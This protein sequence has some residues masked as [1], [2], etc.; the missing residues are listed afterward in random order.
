M[1]K[2]LKGIQTGDEWQQ[3]S[4]SFSEIQHIFRE[5]NILDKKIFIEHEGKR[6]RL[7]CSDQSFIV[8]RVNC[9]QNIPPG[10]PG[11]IV[12]QVDK[13]TDCHE[14]CPSSTVI[15]HLKCK[16]KI[17]DWIDKVRQYCRQ[18]SEVSEK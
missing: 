18:N 7:L 16:L 1:K 15:D 3:K 8:Y 10:I 2:S 13:T 4:I 14:N 9:H 12:C 17:N 5:N 11:W 6:Y